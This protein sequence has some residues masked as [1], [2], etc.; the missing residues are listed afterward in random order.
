MKKIGLPIACVVV[1]LLAALMIEQL[2]RPGP[3]AEGPLTP[4]PVA[5]PGEGYAWSQPAPALGEP[6]PAFTLPLV[7]PGEGEVSLAELRGAP[8]VLVFGSF[9]C[10]V[11]CGQVGGVCELANDYEDRAAFVF[12]YVDDAGHPPP[13]EGP[14]SRY[15]RSLPDLARRRLVADIWRNV[16]KT[17]PC[18]YG[19]QSPAQFAY[20]AFP[21]RLVVVDAE[22]RVAFDA[23][24]GLP[25]GWD[26]GQVKAHL[27]R[28]TRDA[29]ARPKKAGDRHTESK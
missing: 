5:Q 28:L 6:A 25:G 20:H 1:A 8:A 18:L 10:N 24:G 13:K 15:D 26:M 22:G 23:G 12:V 14:L 2:A 16:R 11:F 9:S 4:P 21:Q 3:T 17:I 27:D 19:A 29:P 7:A